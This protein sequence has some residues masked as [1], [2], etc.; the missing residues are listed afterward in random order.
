MAVY[1]DKTPDQLIKQKKFGWTK[2]GGPNRDI[3]V[4]DEPIWYCQVCSREQMKD[5]PSFLVEFPDTP[6]MKICDAC[7]NK[8]I[9]HGVMTYVDL[10]VIVRH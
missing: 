3:I 2:W 5:Y 6:A 7:R 9:T 8:M 4:D 10:I 1:L